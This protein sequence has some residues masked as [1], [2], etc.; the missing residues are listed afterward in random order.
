MGMVRSDKSI[1]ICGQVCPITFVRSKLAIEG[2]A[3]G[4]VLGVLLD[5][6]EAVT[7]I[8]KSMAD[9]GHE[10]ISVERVDDAQWMLLIR[11]DGLMRGE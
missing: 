4:E 1:D 5:Y 6:E 8:P 3:S 10:T 2:M 7:S 9:H 11:K